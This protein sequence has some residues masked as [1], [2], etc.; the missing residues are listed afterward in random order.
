MVRDLTCLLFNLILSGPSGKKT[1]ASWHVDGT[2]RIID[3]L[4]EMAGLDDPSKD[5]PSDQEMPDA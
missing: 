3:S 1:L 4:A 5:K 2:D